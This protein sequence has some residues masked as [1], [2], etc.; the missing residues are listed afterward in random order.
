MTDRPRIAIMGSGGV[1][2]YFGGRLAQ[3]GMDV[4]FIAR[5]AH[6]AA[7]RE[8]GLRINSPLGDAHIEPVRATDNPAEIGPVDYV[9]FATKLWDTQSA[10]EACR[11]LIGPETAVISLQNG[12]DAE[13][14]L[15]VILGADHVMGGVAAIS[16]V[17]GAPGVI[18]HLGGFASISF[19][20]LDGS[21][22]ARAERLMA[23]LHEAG[24]NAKIP[25]DIGKTIW[26][27]FIFLVGLSALTSVTR[28]TIGPLREDP[29][30]RALLA[31]V[32]AE[33]AAV[34]RAR[35]IAIDEDTAEE[36]LTFLDN[37]PAS[38]TSSMAG[39]LERGNRLE[40]DWLSG[41]V[42]RMG[43]ELGVDTPAN[44]FINTALKLSAS[45]RHEP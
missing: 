30:C 17:I 10:G 1:G 7:M 2:G 5:G 6:L 12:V 35:G 3:A 16:A 25:D 31:R 39:D 37:L 34:A 40:L 38:M 8:R 11:P 20:E 4:R 27:K 9:L 33:T 29:E 42:V 19:G 36:R 26:R 14:R 45:G 23:A 15:A 28:K 22:S 18:D 41:A 44:G 24:I 43:R 13:E 32:L 21:R